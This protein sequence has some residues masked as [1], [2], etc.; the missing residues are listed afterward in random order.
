MFATT[1]FSLSTF[2]GTNPSGSKFCQCDCAK[3]TGE[4]ESA[5]HGQ[6]ACL[7][8]A[9]TDATETHYINYSNMHMCTKMMF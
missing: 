5:D 6:T 1:Q 7:K 9:E 3:Y 4:W 8:L 2:S